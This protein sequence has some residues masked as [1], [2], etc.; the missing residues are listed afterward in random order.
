MAEYTQ[1]L[2]ITFSRIRTDKKFQV[3]DCE[4]K[5]TMKT[6]NSSYIVTGYHLLDD[7]NL[8]KPQARKTYHI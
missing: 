6:L 5:N 4:E 1:N 7:N 2:T 8:T 3:K